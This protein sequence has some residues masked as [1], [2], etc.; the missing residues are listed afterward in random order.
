M[1]KFFND[2]CFWGK[3]HFR[4]GGNL[5]A[6]ATFA[7]VILSLFSCT[8]YV[9]QIENERNEWRLRGPFDCSVTDGVKVVSPAGGESFKVDDEITVVFGTAIDDSYRIIFKNSSSDAGIDLLDQSIDVITDGKTCNEVNVKL[10]ANMGVEETSTGIVRVAPYNR[11]NKGANSGTFNVVGKNAKS[12]S[13]AY[14]CSVTDGVK[15]VYPAGGETFNV[16]QTIDVV[17]GTT[18]Y[19]SY[20]IVFK[21]NFHDTGFLL[22]DESFDLNSPADGKTCHTVKVELSADRGVEATSTGII[23]VV[24]YA[25]TSKGANSNSFK[26]L[27]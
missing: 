3:C 14:D 13:G 19:D 27:R 2:G 8:D 21:T 10:S 24:P 9:S 5:L 15:V 12:S 20:Y 4:E 23:R 26:V 6:V 16:G 11:Q 1:K 7:F 22:V 18:V 17:F 25:K